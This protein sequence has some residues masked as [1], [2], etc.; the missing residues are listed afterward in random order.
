MLETYATE[1][2][3]AE[4]YKNELHFYQ[5]KN[6]MPQQFTDTLWIKTSWV[7]QNLRLGLAE[8][9]GYAK[10]PASTR[11]SMQAWSSH[12]QASLQKL[13]YETTSIFTLPA[14]STRW[15]HFG[16]RATTNE[17]SVHRRGTQRGK[18]GNHIATFSSGQLTQCITRN[19]TQLQSFITPIV[20][21][22]KEALW[23]C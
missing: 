11:H 15:N 7:L 22:H 21:S 16:T 20:R 19:T 5:P 4:A 14:S 1:N 12:K 2:V 17:K 13:T 23:L 18:G 8:R 6:S 3:I 10:L 9:Y